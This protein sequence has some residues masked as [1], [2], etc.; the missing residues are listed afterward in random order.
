ML[1]ERRNPIFRQLF[2][3]FRIS[4]DRLPV[5]ARYNRFHIL[6]AQYRTSTAATRHAL[7]A[8]QVSIF[9]PVLASRTDRQIAVI[10][11]QQSL[12]LR[13]R[14]TPQVRRVMEQHLILADLHPD[15]RRRLIAQNERIV[16]G[17]LQVN[18]EVAAAVGG[19]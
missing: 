7:S 19:G 14:F 1:S 11:G 17:F 15:W 8:G 6:V 5:A 13:R 18:P 2:C 12:R 10:A 9:D 16:T 3:L 4:D